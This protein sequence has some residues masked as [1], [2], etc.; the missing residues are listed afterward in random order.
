MRVVELHIEGTCDQ[1][2]ATINAHGAVIGAF[3]HTPRSFA[4]Q[5]HY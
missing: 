4:A 5:K 2:P 1:L 3:P